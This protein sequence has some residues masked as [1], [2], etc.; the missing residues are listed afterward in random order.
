VWIVGS[1]DEFTDK[2]LSSVAAV[3]RSHPSLV[4]TEIHCWERASTIT[5]QAAGRDWSVEDKVNRF[6]KA[7]ASCRMST[8]SLL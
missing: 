2:V 8:N 5:K 1:F 3:S 6:G 4:A 7:V